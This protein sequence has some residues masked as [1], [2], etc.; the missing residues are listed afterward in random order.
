MTTA[1]TL[2]PNEEVLVSGT[3]FTLKPTATKPLYSTEVRSGLD[4][5]LYETINP[6][7][8]IEVVAAGICPPIPPG[9]PNLITSITLTP[10]TTFAAGK[11]CSILQGPVGVTDL[12][13]FNMPLFNEPSMQYGTITF[14]PPGVPVGT[15]VA[16]L[17]G[18]YSEKYFYDQ[19]Y[20]FATYYQTQTPSRFDKLTYVDLING[21]KTIPLNELTGIL[22][23]QDT[24]R[25]TSK[26]FP[27][28]PKTVLFQSIA[29]DDQE[30]VVT[31]GNAL[32]EGLTTDVSAWIKMKPSEIVKMTYYYVLTVTHT[33]PPYITRFYGSMVVNNNWDP[34]QKRLQ[35]YLNKATGIIPDPKK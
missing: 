34:V 8:S 15:L 2:T 31:S 24:G 11:G 9:T 4:P 19:E 5:V 33:C 14:P 29:N 26:T 13:Q 30:A 7:L 16:P 3:T 10:G 22:A 32:I 18:Y 1:V 21:N 25:I 6:S 35:Y 27:G 23:K 12:E 17:K 20:I 28:S